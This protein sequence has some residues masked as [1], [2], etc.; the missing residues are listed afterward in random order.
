MNHA[1]EH[2]C[3]NGIAADPLALALGFRI[4][5]PLRQI[6]EDRLFT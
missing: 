4:L 2:F 3:L 5:W 1:L 6:A